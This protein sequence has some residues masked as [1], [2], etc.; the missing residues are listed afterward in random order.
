[1]HYLIEK[2]HVKILG[3]NVLKNIK[4]KKQ[5]KDPDIFEINL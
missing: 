1:M 4:I 2:K 5:N 3:I